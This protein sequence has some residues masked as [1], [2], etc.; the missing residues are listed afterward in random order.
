MIVGAVEVC[1]E[2]CWS[3]VGVDVAKYVLRSDRGR[4]E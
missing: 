1:E 3:G 2:E 4:G